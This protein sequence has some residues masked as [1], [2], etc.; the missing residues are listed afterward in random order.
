MQAS[1]S[2]VAFGNYIG[3]FIQRLLMP[4]GSFLPFSPSHPTWLTPTTLLKLSCS[5]PSEARTQFRLPLRKGTGG[6]GCACV[7]TKPPCALGSLNTFLRGEHFGG[8]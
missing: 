8:L 3:L 1:T 6:N 2:E 5:V 7:L 4:L